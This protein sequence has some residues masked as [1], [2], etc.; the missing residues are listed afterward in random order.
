M[1]YGKKG[2]RNGVIHY[3]FIEI[4]RY[5]YGNIRLTFFSIS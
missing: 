3:D 4:K 5:Y 1:K 2:E